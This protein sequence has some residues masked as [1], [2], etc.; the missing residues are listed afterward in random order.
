VRLV[1]P[2]PPKPDCDDDDDNDDFLL[3]ADHVTE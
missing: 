2:A 3:F 1:R